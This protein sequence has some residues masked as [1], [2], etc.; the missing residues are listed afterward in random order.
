MSQMSPPA[1]STNIVR[2]PGA[3]ARLVALRWAPGASPADEDELREAWDQIAARLAAERLL[4]LQERVYA[5]AW[6]VPTICSMRREALTARG[7]D[8]ERPVTLVSN[9][10]CI[11]GACAGIHVLAIRPTADETVRTVSAGGARGRL[12]EGPQGRVLFVADLAPDPGTPDPL[13][14][15]F[16]G[17]VDAVTE[18][19]FALTEVAR[20]WLY[21]Q[22]LIP[23]Y[24]HLNA[25]R[26]DVFV[27]EGLK[28]DHE[29]LCP[30]PAS[31]GIQGVHPR[32]SACFLD[33][34][35]VDGARFEPVRP[36]L[37]GEAYDYGSSFSRGMEIELGGRRLVTIS[38]TAS[39]DGDGATLHLDD[40]REQVI[41]TMRN[42]DSL[43]R[44]A[45]ADGREGLW[46]LYF[47]DRAAYDAWRDLVL[48]GEL[49]APPEPVCIFGDVCRDDLLFEAEVTVPL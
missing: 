22:E 16:E 33:L 43:L 26:D 31:T 2:H 42:I 20:T 18:H 41:E 38:G 49:A 12:L 19:G 36:E 9:P 35:A 1:T 6:A 11:E 48:R 32:G 5:P 28:N 24:G 39:I 40:H 27:R 4:V 47:K 45:G 46:T 37:Q 14:A 15:M 7:L 44:R 10:S 29:W 3:R 23:T 25:V 34:I 8:A 21:V 13:R 17:A 30:P